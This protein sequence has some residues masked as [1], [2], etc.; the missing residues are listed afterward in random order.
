M[1]YIIV[2][3]TVYPVD[4]VVQI[5]VAGKANY[6]A[7]DTGAAGYDGER[8]TGRIVFASDG[9]EDLRDSLSGF[10]L[11]SHTVGELFA[12]A[13]R[14]EKLWRLNSGDSGHDDVLYGSYD[15]IVESVGQWLIECGHMDRDGRSDE[16]VF[17]DSGWS[18]E[19]IA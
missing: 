18:L 2:E 1:Q 10:S 8:R 15:G 3:N 13:Q 11:K 9:L 4:T 14:G 5:A 6:D 7:G 12:A 19:E 16:D 17:E